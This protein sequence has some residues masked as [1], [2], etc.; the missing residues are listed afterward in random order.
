MGSP[1]Q[2]CDSSRAEGWNTAFNEQSGHWEEITHAET[3]KP[4]YESADFGPL[5]EL[6]GDA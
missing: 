1:P 3:G 5:E 2:P 6:L 4:P